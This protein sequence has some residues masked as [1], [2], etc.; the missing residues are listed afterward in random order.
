V[1]SGELAL[2]NIIVD[3]G[4]RWTGGSQPQGEPPS[5]SYNAYDTFYVQNALVSAEGTG[6]KI[7]LGAGAVLQNNGNMGT[8]GA[9]RLVDEAE[10]VIRTGAEV[11]YN[12]TSMKGGAIFLDESALLKLSGGKIHNNDAIDTGGALYIGDGS[13]V[14]IEGGEITNNRA[15]SGGALYIQGASVSLSGGAISGN[16]ALVTGGGICLYNGLVTMSGGQIANNNADVMAGGVVISGSSA[17][18]SMS[19]GN[20]SGNF[21][22]EL[23]YPVRTGVLV[24]QGTFSMQDGARVA[25][26]NVVYLVPGT[27]ITITGAF[28]GPGAVA[29]VLPQSVSVGTPILGG[30]TP[31]LVVAQYHRFALHASLSGRTINSAGNL[32]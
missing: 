3:G 32:Q 18:F 19:G 10:M 27:T 13:T 2:E 16:M 9:V 31:P 20:I 23:F 11:R 22:Q 12:Q 26:D 1:S 25:P 7:T 15:A 17:A 5:P 6:T 14:I 24:Q 29:V 28:T 4:T 30:T 21:N 8:G